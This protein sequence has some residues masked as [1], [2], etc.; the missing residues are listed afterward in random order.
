MLPN[1]NKQFQQHQQ[2]HRLIPLILYIFVHHPSQH[3]VTCPASEALRTLHTPALKCH[4]KHRPGVS[5]GRSCCAAAQT[6]CPV[7]PALQGSSSLVP[8]QQRPSSTCSKSSPS[9]R[10]SALHGPAGAEQPG[11]DLSPAAPAT[12][13]P[14][15][16]RRR[17]ADKKDNEKEGGSSSCLCCLFHRMFGGSQVISC[18]ASRAESVIAGPVHPSSEFGGVR[19]NVKHI[20][21]NSYGMGDI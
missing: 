20:K 1:T 3:R 21:K 15:I 18:A 10:S 8:A 13:F 19:D 17:D 11:T 4:P 12:T 14:C 9:S 16:Q 6:A 2:T 5:L 7:Q